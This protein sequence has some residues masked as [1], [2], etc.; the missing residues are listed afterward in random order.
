MTAK[1][2][3]HSRH[4]LIDAMPRDFYSFVRRIFPIISPGSPFL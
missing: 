3:L 4:N 1:T 2:R